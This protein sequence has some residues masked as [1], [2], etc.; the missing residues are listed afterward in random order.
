MRHPGDAA[1]QEFD[2]FW[3][4]VA[5]PLHAGSFG[6]GVLDRTFGGQVR[7][8]KAPGRDQ[9]QNL[10]PSA[11]LQFFGLVEIEPATEVLTVRLIDRDDN[12]VYAQALDPAGFV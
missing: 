2:P 7:F 9:P 11:G 12:E 1:F 8:L 4:F 5:G 10:P 6:P 3:E